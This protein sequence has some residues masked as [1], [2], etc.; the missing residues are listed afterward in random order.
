MKGTHI[1]HRSRL[2]TSVVATHDEYVI[3]LFEDKSYDVHYVVDL[4]SGTFQNGQNVKSDLT[5]ACF[6]EVYDVT[7]VLSVDSDPSWSW[8]LWNL[9]DRRINA[10]S[11]TLAIG[12]KQPNILSMVQDADKPSVY[13]LDDGG[14]LRRATIT[15]TKTSDKTRWQI[16][17]SPWQTVPPKQHHVHVFAQLPDGTLA[18]ADDRGVWLWDS[19]A[20][21][22]RRLGPALDCPPSAM[23]PL[24]DGRLI[25]VC[26][27]REPSYSIYDWQFGGWRGGPARIAG[28]EGDND[29]VCFAAACE[30]RFF[31]AAGERVV[32]GCEAGDLI[33]IDGPI[34]DYTQGKV[35]GLAVKQGHLICFGE[36]GVSVY[37]LTPGQA[38][39]SRAGNRT[40]T[41]KRDWPHYKRIAK[42][43]SP[44]PI[45]VAVSRLEGRLSQKFQIRDKL[46]QI[47]IEHRNCNDQIPNIH[48][49]VESGDLAVGKLHDQVKN[50]EKAVDN[51]L[52]IIK[53]RRKK[54]LKELES[55]EHPTGRRT[56]EWRPPLCY[57]LRMQF[58]IPA[59]MAPEKTGGNP[60]ALSDGKLEREV[61]E[62]TSQTEAKSQR[63]L[64]E[65]S[66]LP[67]GV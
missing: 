27:G 21:D 39:F 42:L 17:L 9:A 53:F 22:R 63:K 57:G 46:T 14:C 25:V 4:L 52:S 50:Y 65:F 64:R 37:L 6:F 54:V 44:G 13:T 26:G 61:T 67:K 47:S 18:Y 12:Q 15:L 28:L 40:L 8:S 66:E 49:E 62:E 31:F 55:V 45:G 33:K 60:P 10:M 32:V 56:R 36:K 3:I 30:K 2:S 5:A 41:P 24:A 20:I 19:V 29:E 34:G 11:P 58:D 59:Y 1:Q 38:E 16:N 23:V 48:Q 7:G 43:P 35:C 51:F